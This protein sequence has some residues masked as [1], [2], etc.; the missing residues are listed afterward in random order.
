MDPAETDRLWQALSTQGTRVAQLE[1]VIHDIMD[2]LQNLTTSVSQLGG[3]LD[4]AITQISTSASPV[5]PQA[6]S[7]PPAPPA[8][9]SISPPSLSHEPYIPTSA[10]YSDLRNAYHLI[11]IK[12]GDEWKMAFNT[13]LGHFE[14][15]VIRFSLTNASAV[16]QALINDVL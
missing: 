15:L 1:R 12:E 7:T 13:P 2:T 16:F 11:R 8:A 9:P 3:R 4:Q 10:R 14:Y 6:S 5:D